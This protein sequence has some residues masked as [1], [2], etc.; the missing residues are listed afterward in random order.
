MKI[1]KDLSSEEIFRF[2]EIVEI[3][4][5]NESKK[6]T[7]NNLS[8][9]NK[10]YTA[11]VLIVFFCMCF[12]LVLQYDLDVKRKETYIISSKLSPAEKFKNFVHFYLKIE[13]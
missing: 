11:V 10:T 2:F 7:L 9:A 3:Q 4:G 1:A 8:M 12:R 5:A 6:M 13:I